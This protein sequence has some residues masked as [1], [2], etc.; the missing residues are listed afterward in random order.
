MSR[1]TLGLLVCALFSMLFSTVTVAVAQTQYGSP[2]KVAPL[3]QA[4]CVDEMAVLDLNGDGFDDVLAASNAVP[5]PQNVALPIQILLNDGH[6]GFFDGTSQ[7]ITGPVPTAVT[8]RKI[9]I[10]DFNGDG[11]PDVFI[12]DHG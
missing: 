1:R 3:A 9:V 7:V 11:K 5:F 4:C 2:T 6:G 12:A 10:A 8:P